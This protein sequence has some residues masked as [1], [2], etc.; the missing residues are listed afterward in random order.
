MNLAIVAGGWHYPAH[1]YHRVSRL[2]SGADLFCVAHRP[3][4]AV[5]VREEKAFL[6]GPGHETGEL[7]QIDRE[8]YREPLTYAALNWMDWSY[9]EYPNTA[10]DWVF[11]NQ[12]L[13]THDYRAYDMILNCHDDTYF[14][15]GKNVFDLVNEKL[16]GWPSHPLIIANG[17][18]PRGHAPEGYVRGSFEFWSPQLLDMLGGRI[19]MPALTLTREGK[20]DTPTEFNALSPWN[21]TC[22]PLREWMDKEKLLDRIAY[23]SPHYR[24]SEYVIEGER[25]LV[26]SC[27]G[28]PWSFED[29]LKEWPL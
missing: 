24:V 2:A 5:E 15:P 29:G 20:T 11:F 23:L 22:N 7:R 19:P 17:R 4:D 8:M 9:A 13:E 6:Y 18:I 25:G 28:A 10:G 27:V 3:L 12:W 14:R 1:F 16:T 21:A 26:S